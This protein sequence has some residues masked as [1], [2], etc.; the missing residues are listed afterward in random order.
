MV[1]WLASEKVRP[2]KSYFSSAFEYV[3]LPFSSRAPKK[4]LN[5]SSLDFEDNKI[6]VRL[7]VTSGSFSGKQPCP[8]KTKRIRTERSFRTYNTTMRKD[9]PYRRSWP[10]QTQISE[11]KCHINHSA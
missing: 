11:T 7:V 1:P 9:F 10:S 8:N 3:K 4:Y 6:N 2:K 5:E